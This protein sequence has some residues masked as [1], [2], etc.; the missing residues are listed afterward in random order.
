MAEINAVLRWFPLGP[1]EGPLEPITT[2][3]LEEVSRQCGVSI[4]LENM[5]GAMQDETRGRAIE[6]IT[7]HIVSISSGDERAF[8]NAIRT[9]VKKYR[10]PRT[11]YATLGSDRRAE[12]IIRDEFNQEDGWY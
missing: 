7:Q 8:R 9:L 5:R 4:L 12:R 10:A 2:E 6:G 3:G 1:I 11:T